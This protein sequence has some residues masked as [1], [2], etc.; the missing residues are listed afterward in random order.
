MKGK[1]I[2]KMWYLC[3]CV[4]GGGGGCVCV[5]GGEA[6]I[7]EE[8]G[9]GVQAERMQTSNLSL[10]AHKCAWPTHLYN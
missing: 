8:A 10:Q 7:D 5:W 6:G 9:I 4:G 3:V 2:E 1:C